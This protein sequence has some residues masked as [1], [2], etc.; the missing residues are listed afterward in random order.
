MDWICYTTVTAVP[1][2]LVY[3]SPVGYGHFLL[4]SKTEIRAGAQYRN[5][6]RVCFFASDGDENSLVLFLQ[7]RL[8]VR[9]YSVPHASLARKSIRIC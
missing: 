1:E 5:P 8:H 3:R 9:R 2:N 4:R 7:N 6:S